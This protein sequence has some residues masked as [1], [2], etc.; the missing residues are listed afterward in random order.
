MISSACT[1]WPSDPTSSEWPTSPSC[2]RWPARSL[3]VVLDTWS[4]II[5]WA[6]SADL[7]TRVALTAALDMALVARA[8]QWIRASFVRPD[9]HSDGPF[10][11]L[12]PQGDSARPESERDALDGSAA[13][14]ARLRRANLQCFLS[15]KQIVFAA[16]RRHRA[17]ALSEVM[18]GRS[19]LSPWHPDKVGLG[20]V[21]VELPSARAAGAISGRQQRRQDQFLRRYKPS[22]HQASA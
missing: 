10:G 16:T 8:R 13:D 2:R 22:T 9:S 3:A 12:A 14:K 20:R 15:R 19:S 11:G 1:S 7:K 21:V 17:L 6:F 5:G 18:G 4:R